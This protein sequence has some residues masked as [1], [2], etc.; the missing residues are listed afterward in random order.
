MF[1]CSGWTPEQT[2][3]NSLC[4]AKAKQNLFV[5]NRFQTNQQPWQPD[6]I[7]NTRLSADGQQEHGKAGGSEP[8]PHRP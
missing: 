6:A 5:V 4:A 1:V 8:R 7:V 3:L 2:E